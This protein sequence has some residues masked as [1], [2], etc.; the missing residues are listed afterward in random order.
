MDWDLHWAV[1]GVDDG[2]LETV[3]VMEMLLLGLIVLA[4]WRIGEALGGEMGSDEITEDYGN[5]KTRSRVAN[6]PIDHRA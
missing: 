5:D 6:K 2:D 1:A 3:Q 4:L